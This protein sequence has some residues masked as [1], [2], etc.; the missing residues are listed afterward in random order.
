VDKEE[1]EYKHFLSLD[2]MECCAGKNKM[3]LQEEIHLKSL[4]IQR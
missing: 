3:L 1:M 4:L 2:H